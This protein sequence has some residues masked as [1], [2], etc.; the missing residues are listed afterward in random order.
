[1]K[2]ILIKIISY[3]IQPIIIA[4][5]QIKYWL[6][7][8]QFLFEINNKILGRAS[9]VSIPL[10]YFVRI[11]S[12]MAASLNFFFGNRHPLGQFL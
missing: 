8:N 6:F 1:M 9:F 5:F 10:I 2:N 4:T 11:I 3:V 7:S 12:A